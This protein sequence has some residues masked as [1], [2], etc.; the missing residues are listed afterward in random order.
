ANFSP[1]SRP[2]RRHGPR[3]RSGGPTAAAAAAAL[4]GGRPA[5]VRAPAS[6]GPSA[7]HRQ[8][9]QKVETHFAAVELV[10]VELHVVH[11]V[12]HV[13][14]DDFLHGAVGHHPAVL[15]GHDVV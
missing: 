3:S 10:D 2:R 15:H 12:Q 9:G 4:S 1:N 5:G 11:V 8:L 7:G 14:A 13:L 6:G